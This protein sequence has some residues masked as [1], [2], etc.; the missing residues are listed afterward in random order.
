MEKPFIAANH[1]EAK[2]TPFYGKVYITSLFIIKDMI[3][4]ENLPKVAHL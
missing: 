4:G 2:K 1:G 3:T